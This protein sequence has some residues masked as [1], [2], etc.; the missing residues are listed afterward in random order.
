MPVS[1]PIHKQECLDI[2]YLLEEQ[3]K[4]VTAS[5][6]KLMMEEKNKLIKQK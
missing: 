3:E 1:H 6:V 4:F 5:F 2:Y